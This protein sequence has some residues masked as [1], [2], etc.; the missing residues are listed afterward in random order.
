LDAQDKPQGLNPEVVIVDGQRMVRTPAG[1]LIT[2]AHYKRMTTPILP[3]VI[4]PPLVESEE[5]GRAL[6]TRG[7]E[8]I[9]AAVF[10]C[11]LRD[12]LIS[13]IAQAQI[14]DEIFR[15]LSAAR[16]M[17]MFI[18]DDLALESIAGESG[19]LSSVVN[20]RRTNPGP[21]PKPSVDVRKRLDEI[22]AKATRQATACLTEQILRLC[23][24][25]GTDRPMDMNAVS[26]VLLN[27]GVDAKTANVRSLHARVARMRMSG[28]EQVEGTG[29]GRRRVGG[30]TDTATGTE[31][32]A[33]TP[34]LSVHDKVLR[35]A[36]LD[37]LREPANPNMDKETI[38]AT[39]VLALS[40]SD[41]D[42]VMRYVAR[43]RAENPDLAAE[44]LGDE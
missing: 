21:A 16:D 3:P 13:S 42:F 2:E 24:S 34:W 44:L 20:L 41:P 11:A 36:I 38:I 10:L 28:F 43:F 31:N 17:A 4:P 14:A 15:L 40:L 22:A 5:E 9:N 33:E 26:R 32:G 29:R 25:R 23:Q 37:A 39:G 35:L 27:I 6:L 19:Q 18:V 30:T 12:S 1:G 7:F 8:K